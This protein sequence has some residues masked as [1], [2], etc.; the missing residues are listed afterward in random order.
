[1]LIF[2]VLGAH[3]TPKK[4]FTSPSFDAY[5]YLDSVKNEKYKIKAF[6]TFDIKNSS[7][8]SKS[9]F[10]SQLISYECGQNIPKIVEEL[11]AEKPFGKGKKITNTQEL[12]KARNL[13]SSAYP[14]L[15]KET[16]I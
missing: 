16:C 10:Y 7:L 13:V 11:L 3:S 6:I 14:S 5:L 15:F 12:K 1:M 4:I 2:F 8:L 9:K